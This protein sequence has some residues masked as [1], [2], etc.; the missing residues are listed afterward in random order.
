MSFFPRHEMPGMDTDHDASSSESSSSSG[1]HGSGSMMAMVFQT[2]TSTPLYSNSWT[3]TS[4]GAYAGTCIFLA[5]LAIIARGLLAYKAVQE[6]H[7]LDREA[8]RRYVAVNG[9]LPLAEQIASSPDARRMTLSENG[10][11]ETVVVV[12]RKRAVTRPW[13]FSVDPIRACLDTVIVGI[14][15]LLMLAVMT[16][17]VGYFLSVLAGVFVGS[18]AVGRYTQVI[19]H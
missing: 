13:R 2:D 5:I 12:E 19:D 17:N 1:S 10:L 4:A 15:Y 6:A 16:M 8:A 7:W 9:K 18:L 3:P 14:G 11:E